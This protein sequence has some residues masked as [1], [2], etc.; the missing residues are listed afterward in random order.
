MAKQKYS[1]EF[2]REAVQMSRQPGASVKQ[3]AENIGIHPNVLSRWRSEMEKVGEKAFRGQGV[4]R[5]EE[6]AKLRRDLSR[7][8]RE[9]DFLKETAAYF[10]KTSR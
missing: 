9:R 2:K 7:V 3:V 5:D 4:P 6:V 10:A 8:T 1:A